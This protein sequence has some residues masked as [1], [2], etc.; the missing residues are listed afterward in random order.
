VSGCARYVVHD[1]LSGRGDTAA[2]NEGYVGISPAWGRQAGAVRSGIRGVTLSLDKTASAA[3]CFLG[4]VAEP[5]SSPELTP[6]V[7]CD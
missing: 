2:R 6:A 3:M 1:R 4:A 7:T 5:Q